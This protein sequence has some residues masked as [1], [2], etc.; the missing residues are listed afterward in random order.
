MR[1]QLYLAKNKAQYE[2]SA[3]ENQNFQAQKYH[4]PMQNC[5]VL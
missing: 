4:E 2:E 3:S 5:L 1:I